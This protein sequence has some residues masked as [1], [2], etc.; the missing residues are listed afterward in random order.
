MVRIRIGKND[1][2]DAKSTQ[3][4]Q[5]REL[6]KVTDKEMTIE[7]AECFLLRQVEGSLGRCRNY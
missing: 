7:K 2:K 4:S 3:F 1:Q 5:E 6:F